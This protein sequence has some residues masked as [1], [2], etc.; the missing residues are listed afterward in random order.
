[1]GRKEAMVLKPRLSG[2]DRS[3][4][5]KPAVRLATEADLS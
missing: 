5:R 2:T 4:S 1:M 3:C